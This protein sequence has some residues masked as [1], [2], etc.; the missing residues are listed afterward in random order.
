MSKRKISEVED[1]APSGERHEKLRIQEVDDLPSARSPTTEATAKAIDDD[2]GSRKT[3]RQA[4]QLAKRERRALRKAKHNS[5]KRPDTIHEGHLDTVLSA[6]QTNVPRETG[7]EEQLS[8]PSGALQRFDDETGHL[9]SSAS[10][11]VD[12]HGLGKKSKWKASSPISGQMLELDP[13]FSDDEQYA[14]VPYCRHP[15]ADPLD[16]YILIAYGTFVGVYSTSTSLLVRRLQV[17][18][19]SIISGFALDPQNKSHVHVSV[20]SGNIRCWDWTEGRQLNNRQSSREIHALTVAAKDA[21][22]VNNDV[23]Y[24]VRRSQ[25]GEWLIEAH[26][27]IMKADEDGG[28]ARKILF[29]FEHRVTNLH[30]IE[31]G[32]II[33]AASAQKLIIGHTR[34]AVSELFNETHY[35]WRIVDCPDFITSL[36]VRP[37]PSGRTSHKKH[38]DTVSKAVD[39][40]IGSLRGVIHVYEDILHKLLQ[41]ERVVKP[42]KD[43]GIVSR[44]LH[45]HRTAVLSVKWSLDGKS[46]SACKMREISTL[47]MQAITLSPVAKRQY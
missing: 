4:R 35:D 1:N 33:V 41:M 29:R 28:V 20:Q 11:A 15:C 18:E 31:S 17:S 8:V 3:D 30:V 32:R 26:R 38:Y 44:R 37:R 36:D 12:Q 13:I 42:G 6:S 19:A 27:H 21:D 23:L 7:T 43:D 16:R 45:W 9:R 39:V 10:Q 5:N 24:T 22:S 34:K 47:I 14:L 40:V 46:L 2:R 25:S